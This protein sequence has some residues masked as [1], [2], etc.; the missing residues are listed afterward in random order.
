MDFTSPNRTV[1]ASPPYGG[2]GYEKPCSGCRPL[3]GFVPPYLGQGSLLRNA[4]LPAP[5]VSY[6]QNVMQHCPLHYFEKY[7]INN[8]EQYTCMWIDEY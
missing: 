8:Y 1:T 4:L 2:S 5:N 6:S 7:T 3:H